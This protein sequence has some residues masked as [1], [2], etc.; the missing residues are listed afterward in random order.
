MR[1][2]NGSAMSARLYVCVCVCCFL[3]VIFALVFFIFPG[4]PMSEF[5]VCEVMNAVL[6]GHYSYKCLRSRSFLD[7]FALTLPCCVRCGWRTC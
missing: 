5:L 2:T 1:R 7:N 3:L 4:F 6:L